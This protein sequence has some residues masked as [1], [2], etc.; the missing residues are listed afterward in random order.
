MISEKITL[1]SVEIPKVGLGTYQVT[2]IE[3]TK[4]IEDA[5]RIGYRHIDTAQAYDNEEEVG[6]AIKNSGISREQIFI[7][8]K[9]WPSNFER[10]MAAVEGSLEKLK[11]GYTDLLLLHWPSDDEANK[12]AIDLL[13]EALNKGYTKT[14]GVSNFN[15]E[16]LARAITQAPIICNQ[17]EYHPFISQQKIL[18]Y[19]REQH[20]FLTAYSPLA[21]GKVFKNETLQEIAKKHNRT[22]SQVTLRWLIQ[23]GDIAVVPKASST[24][25]RKENLCIFD[26]ELTNDDMVTISGLDKGERLGNPAWAP[27]WD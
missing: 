26:F 5:L 21:L 7:T 23:Q 11:T 9:V 16:Q 14:I 6:N 12:A 24:E 3:G 15:L 8:T 4:S 27:K 10:L 1:K 13:N 25:R 2:G 19:L 20:M 18:N 22:T 17:V